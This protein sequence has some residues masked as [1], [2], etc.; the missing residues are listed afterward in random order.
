MNQV[1]TALRG[2]VTGFSDDPRLSQTLPASVYTSQKVFDFEM[3]KVFAK[4]WQFVGHKNDFSQPGDFVTKTIGRG[5]RTC[6]QRTR[7]RTPRL[8]QCLPPSCPSS[9]QRKTRFAESGCDLPLSL[10]G[11]WSGWRAAPL[12]RQERC[13]RFRSLEDRAGPGAH[14]GIWQLRLYQPG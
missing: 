8:P 3:E 1:E 7:W 12:E 2:D 14:R 6:R 10:L 13:P 11:L 9:G 4:T 5:Q